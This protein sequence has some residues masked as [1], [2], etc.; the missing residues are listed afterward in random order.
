MKNATARIALRVCALGTCGLLLSTACSNDEVTD[1]D[2][3]DEEESGSEGSPIQRTE[4]LRAPLFDKLTSFGEGETKQIDE[5]L[6]ELQKSADYPGLAVAIVGDGRVLY[7]GAVGFAD[8]ESGREFTRQTLWHVAS[9]TKVFTCTLAV[10]LDARSVIDLD[11]PVIEYLPA[12]VS[13]STDPTRGAAITLRQLASHTSGLP[14]RV[15]DDVQ[16][17]EGRYALEPERLYEQLG[18]VELLSDPGSGREY[19]NLGM[20]LLGHVLE[21]VAGRS[22]DQLLKEEVLAPL[23]MNTSGISLEEEYRGMLA[24]GYGEDRPRVVTG[25]SY[26]GRLAGS[27]GLITSIAELSQF[28]I[29]QMPTAGN[30]QPENF[31]TTPMLADLHTATKLNDGSDASTALGWSVRERDS[32]GRYLKK[33]GGRSNTDAW[34]GFSP[35]AG[36]G[37]AVM[38]NGGGPDVD[39]IGIWLLERSVPDADPEKLERNPEVEEVFARVAPFTGVRW[40]SDDE[41]DADFDQPT[42]EVRGE[43]LR[44]TAVEGIPIERLMQTARRR[45]G[46]LARKRFTEDLV[47]LLAAADHDPDWTVTLMLDR[48]DGKGP[49]PFEEKMT[50]AKR[51]AAGQS[52]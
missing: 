52:E 49:Q 47:E 50:K 9:V 26:L 38:T 33:N 23:N 35:D 5:W 25:N 8:I 32:I 24:T 31:L 43:W 15:P 20:G 41:A 46:E 12:G 44:L 18:E 6:S 10:K 34:I 19:S 2:V 28:L 21:R 16:S 48:D 7:Q 40:G 37:V 1:A 45:F 42:V 30:A 27:G 22:L 36:V 14:R 11:R 29:A 51:K 3:T 4:I 17:V 39:Q 13:I